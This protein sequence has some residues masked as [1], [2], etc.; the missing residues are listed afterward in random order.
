VRESEREEERSPRK[1]DIHVAEGRVKIVML[2]NK[3]ILTFFYAFY[4]VG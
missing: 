3:C 1:K 2:A 4:A